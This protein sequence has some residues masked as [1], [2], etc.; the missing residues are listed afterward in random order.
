[1]PNQIES[2]QKIKI[3]Q[4][5]QTEQLEQTEQKK[6]KKPISFKKIQRK[7]FYFFACLII[8]SIT[9]DNSFESKS[10]KIGE[11]FP[12][13]DKKN[14]ATKKLAIKNPNLID[15]KY[16]GK[17]IPL[18]AINKNDK[19][20][21]LKVALCT[22]GKL[23]NLYVKE[24]VDYYV[25]LGIDHLFIY[26]D[27][28]PNTERISDEIENKYKPF[29]T[30]YENM[31]DT[32]K[33]QSNAFTT[34]YNNNKDNF[35]WFLMVDMDE[36]LYIKNDTLKDYLSKQVFDKCDFIKPHWICSTDNNLI[37]YEPKPLFERFTGPFIKY[38]YIKTIIRGSIPNL[39]YWV[40]SPKISP[41][42]NITCDNMG[43]KFDNKDLNFERVLPINIEKAFIIHFRFKST[44]EFV[45]KYK[46]GY[47]DWFGE[48]LQ[49]FLN[50]NIAEYLDNN[51]LT[52]EKIEYIEKELNVNLQKYKNKLLK[53]FPK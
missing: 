4:V 46:R 1:M 7:L 35:D 16:D 31:K 53:A 14:D 23:E 6:Q 48:R 51:D 3:D 19:A 30:V 43:K 52:M 32:I 18:T 42:R 33:H 26:D 40:H 13:K 10:N 21:D 36:Y 11:R 47:S 41:V 24:F 17:E 44:E 9:F 38:K 2:R 29:V 39:T 49:N 15:F 20:N 37:Y 12:N 8:I 28:D 22:M 34:C 27:N 25:K 50:S 45:M 5:E